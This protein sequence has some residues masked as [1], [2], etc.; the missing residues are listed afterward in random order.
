MLLLHCTDVHIDTSHAL[1]QWTVP[2]PWQN[3]D[4]ID[5]VLKE[6]LITNRTLI[7]KTSSHKELYSTF[8]YALND[9]DLITEIHRAMRF[10]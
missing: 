10:K 6:V 4:Q 8:N 2:Y 5:E 1:E 7:F 9:Q 3:G